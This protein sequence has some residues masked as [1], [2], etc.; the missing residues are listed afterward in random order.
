MNEDVD[1]ARETLE[2]LFAEKFNMNSE[3]F[4]NIDWEL[5]LNSDLSVVMCV[6]PLH[7]Y[8]VMKEVT[9][10]KGCTVK[11]ASRSKGNKFQPLGYSNY[12]YIDIVDCQII[13]FGDLYVK[14]ESFVIATT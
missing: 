10:K 9:L 8:R 11:L 1:V 6:D 2:E 7:H 3:E 12:F 14:L 13:N 4:L 5:K